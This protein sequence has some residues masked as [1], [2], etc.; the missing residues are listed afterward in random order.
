[1]TGFL[2]VWAVEYAVP[3]TA[4]VSLSLKKIGNWGRPTGRGTAC[5]RLVEADSF[6]GMLMKRCFVYGL[7]R[8]RITRKRERTG[9]RIY[10][11]FR[12]SA[13]YT[14]R[15]VLVVSRNSGSAN[16]VPLHYDL[17]VP[18]NSKGR[19]DTLYF[20]EKVYH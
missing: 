6:F 5:L 15:R 1:M 10:V 18:S 11:R 2:R 17:G 13:V 8:E 9:C 14:V 12:E 19:C 20:P 16:A 7:P 3:Y 4:A